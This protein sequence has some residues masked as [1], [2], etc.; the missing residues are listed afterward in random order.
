[1]SD[2]PSD[3]PFH[4][5]TA[6]AALRALDAPA[7]GLTSDEAARRLTRHGPNALP[8]PPRRGP[9]LRFLAQFRNV[10][11]YVLLASAA[12]TA[13]LQHWVDA[14]VILA[15]VLVNAAIGF[16]QEGRAEQAMEAIRVMLAPRAAVLR[17]GRRATLDA[18]DLVPGDVV[19]VEAGDR[20]PADL[21]LLEA[22]GLKVE[23]AILTG[24]SVPVDKAV[25]PVPAEAAL[26]DRASMLFSGTIVAAGTGRG[27]V[28]ATA[29]NSQIG[30]IGALLSDVEALTTPLL[31][32]MDLFARWL[33]LF[34][35]AVAAAV[36]AWGRL[37]GTMP[38]ADLFMAVVGL[39]VAAIPEGLPAV[40]TITLA[41]GVQS[42]ARRNAIVRRLPAIETLGAV[43]VICT[44]KT[45]TLTRNEMAVA[46]LAADGRIYSVEASGYAPA[47]AVRWQEAEADPAEHAVLLDFARAAALCNDAGLHPGRDGWRIEGDPMEG[48][49]MALAGKI[50]GEGRAP[51]PRW[52]RSDAIPFDV[53]HRY[54]AVL[55]HDH[56]GRAAIHVKGAPEAVLALCADQRAHDGG[57]RP[58]DAEGWRRTVEDLAAQ[59]QRVIAVAMRATPPEH[60]VL[61]VADLQGTLTLIGL[62]GLV[63]PLRAAAAEAVAECRRAGIAV[64]M[65]TGDHVATARAIAA[66]VGLERPDR[67]LTGAEID[68]MDDA[69][70]AQ[71]AQEADVFARTSPAHKLRLVSALQSRGLT[72]AMTGDGVNDA[73]ALKRAD[74]G[75]AMGLKGSAAARQAAEIVLADD[76]FASIVAAVREGRTAYDNIKKVIGWT[77]PTSAGEAIT[78]VAALLAGLALPITAVQ[79]LWV[80]LVTAATLGLALAFEPTEPGTMRRPPRA[81]DAPL[82]TRE[83]LWHV[84]LV[85]TLILA[86]VFGIYAWATGQGRAPALAQTLAMNA[87]VVLEIFHLFF[88]RNIHGASLTWAAARG[89]PV[90][91]ACVAAVTAAQVAITYLPPLQSAFGT[92][93]V[94]LTDGL[95]I[96]AVGIVFFAL[97]EAEKRIRLALHGRRSVG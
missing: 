9:L 19:L 28:A 17:D 90:V 69:A 37:A 30:R 79:I 22:R 18:A 63:D 92:Q 10:L 62:I 55:H 44:D 14:G 40:L 71:A 21:R 38:F 81:R 13:A 25:A 1:M 34:I 50:T 70:L 45:G 33:T 27:V 36:L 32:Q 83:L 93:A 57:T 60:V 3:R 52:S 97:L 29:G 68:A 46:A 42:M 95:L 48:A 80:N 41:A 85:S 56:A 51:F 43:S 73:P 59:G 49:L 2:A 64:K 7:G 88:I 16:I 47:G 78:I 53:A 8:E 61:D 74:A 58:L 20:I 67:T 23:E 39:S 4:A 91:W 24:E 6:E 12:V 54:M 65:I 66:Q 94:P 15:V 84:A 76:D 75:V 26:G 35:L 96:I 86:A 11:I 5:L 77:L 31:R 72:V 87:L 89:T 82:L